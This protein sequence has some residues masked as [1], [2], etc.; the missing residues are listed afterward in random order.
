[1]TSRGFVVKNLQQTPTQHIKLSGSL[2][3]SHSLLGIS[4]FPLSSYSL[5]VQNK[6]FSRKLEG[7]EFEKVSAELSLY[8]GYIYILVILYYL[9]YYSPIYYLWIVGARVLD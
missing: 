5:L 4:I 2:Q 9:Y 7:I 8:N 3:N 6:F 1:M